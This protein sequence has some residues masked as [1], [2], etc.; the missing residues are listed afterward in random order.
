MILALEYS[1]VVCVRNK[2]H[3]NTEYYWHLFAENEYSS[4][5]LIVI[6]VGNDDRMFIFWVKLKHYII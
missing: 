4:F 5:I 1:P 6:W 2:I 3:W